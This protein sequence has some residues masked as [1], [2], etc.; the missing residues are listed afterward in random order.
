MKKLFVVVCLLACLHS[1]AQTAE[2][3]WLN[4]TP[5]DLYGTF[6]GD[7]TTPMSCAP[8]W[9]TLMYAIP[10]TSYSAVLA[11]SASWGGYPGAPVAPPNNFNETV[12]MDYTG[13]SFVAAM[14][15]PFCGLPNG[16]YPVTLNPSMTTVYVDLVHHLTYI[17]LTINP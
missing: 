8:T 11:G 6:I 13:G 5:Y 10:T 4:K 1:H 16:T 15:F 9:S 12:L 17:E 7:N 14:N 2:V 3:R